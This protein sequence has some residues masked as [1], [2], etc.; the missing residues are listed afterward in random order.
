MRLLQPW[1][2]DRIYRYE[3][4]I[5]DETSLDMP[6]ESRILSVAASRTDEL[7]LE[8]WAAVDTSRASVT[9]SFLV[10]GTGNPIPSGPMSYHGTVQTHG[11]Q[12][13]WHLLERA[14]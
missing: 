4:P 3:I 2:A 13:V 14:A 12:F 8:L 9:R 5:V 7:R 1:S 6:A 10:V 11:G